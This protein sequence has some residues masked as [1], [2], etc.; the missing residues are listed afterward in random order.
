M[1][2]K[3]HELEKKLAE[4]EAKAKCGGSRN[5][6]T[7]MDRVTEPKLSWLPQMGCHT[8]NPYAGSVGHL[9]Y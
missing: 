4:V 9:Q 6:A 2:A 7:C 5:K 8:V 3:Q 1:E